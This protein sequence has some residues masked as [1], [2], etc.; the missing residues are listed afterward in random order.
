MANTSTSKAKITNL[1]WDQARAASIVLVSGPEDFL[2]DRAERII[3]T[4]LREQH[5]EL[6]ISQFDAGL[7]QAGQL[8][9]AASPSLFNEPRLLLVDSVEKCTD[10]FISESVHYLEAIPEDTTLILRHRSGVRGKKLLDAVRALGALAVEISCQEIKRDQDKSQFVQ[11][12]FRNAKRQASPQAIRLLVSALGS[13]LA[14]LAAACQQLIN[15]TS[16]EIDEA[17]VNRYYADRAEVTAFQVIDEALAGRAGKAL[18]MLRQSLESGVDAVPIAAAFASKFRTMALVAY[19]RQHPEAD[20]GLKLPD[21][22]LDRA[23]RDLSNWTDVGLG[24]VITAIA[25]VDSGLKGN[26][27]QP[28]Y[29]LEKL[30]ELVARQG[31][32]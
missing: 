4:N 22:L 2:A 14:G 12:E 29:L 26:S 20:T 28:V 31:R 8:L 24:R 10:D 7:Y 13:D 15:D 19:G 6:E 30:V 18:I 17:L 9:T 32:D 27:R 25:E 1:S 21:W 11:S 3:R 23:R 16:G 5:P